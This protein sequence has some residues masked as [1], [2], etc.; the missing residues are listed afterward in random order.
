MTKERGC[1][2]V[3]MIPGPVA[4]KAENPVLNSSNMN[5][6]LVDEG[7]ILVPF[8]VFFFECARLE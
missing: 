6:F 7:R 5:R 4:A 1:S 8:V 2:Q 3:L